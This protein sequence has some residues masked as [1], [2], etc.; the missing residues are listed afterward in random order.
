MNSRFFLALLIWSTLILLSLAWNHYNENQQTE[1][2]LISVA[3]ANFEKDV[4]FRLW[5]TSHGGV[6]VPVDERTPPS[7]Y[8]AHIPERDLVTPSGRQLTLMNPA[9]MLRQLMSDFAELYGIRGRI[10]S[11]KYLNPNNAPDPW[12]TEALLA[13]EKG[14]KEIMTFASIEGEK[15]L[16]LMQPLVT[17]EGCLKCHGHQGYQ[18]GD[19]RGGV[20]VSVPLAP[21]LLLSHISASAVLWSHGLIWLLGGSAIAFA[22][23]LLGKQLIALQKARDQAEA[24]NRAKSIFLATMSHEIR[25]PMNVVI[26][27]GDV[28]LETA[29]NPEQ[30]H[31]VRKLQQAGDGLVDLIN[32]ILDFS[33]MEADQ[34]EI[35]PARFSLPELLQEV[36]ELLKVIADEKGLPIVLTIH[37][38]LPRWVIGDRLR[39]RQV[40]FNLLGNAIKFTEQGQVTLRAWAE[41]EESQWLHLEVEDSGIGIDEKDL[42]TIFELFSQVEASVTRRFGGTGLG[43]AVSRQLVQRM[44]G[45]INVSSR[46]GAGSCFHLRLPLPEST[47]PQQTPAPAPHIAADC[48][49]KTILLVEDSEDNQ[50]L[51]QAFLKNTPF[52]VQVANHGVEAVEKVKQQRFDLILMDVQMP[53]M[54]GYTATGLI[55]QWERENGRDPTIIIAFTAHALS[56]EQERSQHAGCNFHLTKPIKKARLIEIMHRFTCQCGPAP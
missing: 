28:L 43:L 20:G 14:A 38:L 42:D 19:V 27:M 23:H 31:Y 54:D 22:F 40:L 7:P 21:Y 10:T 49:N 13:F 44:G 32:Q 48:R 16:R 47:P 52:T 56:G 6:Y 37:P 36:C 35:F 30:Q 2:L 18:V 4:A 29:L 17:T 5:A 51:V 26:G 3:R 25:T 9:Y 8:L 45:E 33:K 55:R 50:I 41:Q 34:L 11:L 24:A 46:L 15:Y 39:L 12:E 1:Q 53:I